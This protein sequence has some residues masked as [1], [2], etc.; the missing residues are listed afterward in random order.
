MNPFP[1]SQQ[2]ARRFLLESQQLLSG[3]EVS[4]ESG[5]L[6]KTLKMVRKLECV[7]L[8][9]VSV[10]ERNQHLVLAAR[11]PG[12]KPEYLNQLLYRGDVFEYIAN[13]ACVIPIEDYPLFKPVRK[14]I[15][16][17]LEEPLENSERAVKGV[18]KRLK[19]EGPL[20]SREFKSENRVHGYWD[21][22]VA[23]TKETSHALNLLLDASI[24]RV[25][26]REGNER[27][28]NLTE[29]SVPKKILK[30]AETIGDLEAR[31]SLIDKY[32]RAYRLIDPRDS[33]FGWQKMTAAERRSEVDELVKKEKLV[34]LQ[35]EHAKREYF[36]MTEDLYKLKEIS[37]TEP[38]NPVEGPVR[39]LS[40]L[41][42][43]LWS[44]ER[45]ADLFGFHYRW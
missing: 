36:I 4:T 3:Q 34:P 6:E 14:R 16:E 12:Y 33:R 22:K 27:Y 29:S 17:Q 44:R 43:L 11:I 1:V 18:L 20:P 21:N 41:D 9:P 38:R 24:I 8:D 35:I 13:A 30:E 40:P 39:F 45:L 10:V 25:V 7:Q 28:F 2:T 42:N 15:W 23:K 32:I 19:N 37:Q 5:N 26:H 31:R